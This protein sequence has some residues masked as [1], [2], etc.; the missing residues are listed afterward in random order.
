MHAHVK[1]LM[2]GLLLL[3]LWAFSSQLSTAFAQGTAF[4][5]QGQLTT[6]NGLAAGNYNFTFSLYTN[7]ASG[8]AVA[9]PVTNNAV[10]V[11]NGLF[12]TIVDFGPGVFNGTNYWL[13]LAVETN[14]AS[15]FANLSPRQLLTPAPYAIY[16]ESASNVLGPVLLSQ[17]PANV[18]TNNETNV[19]LGGTF[20]GNGT[21]L[22]IS[23]AQLP[24][25]VT[26]NESNVNLGGTF[27]GVFTGGGFNGMGVLTLDTVNNLGYQ[28]YYS[29]AGQLSGAANTFGNALFGNNGPVD[30]SAFG[31]SYAA[32]TF[33]CN[34]NAGGLYLIE[35][36]AE[37]ETAIAAGSMTIRAF[38]TVPPNPGA[39]IP[40][41]QVSLDSG[42]FAVGTYVTVSKS[43]LAVFAPGDMLNIQFAST[44]A[45]AVNLQ[46]PAGVIGANQPSISVTII[47]IQ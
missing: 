17:L 36:D 41:S 15:T 35:Y 38:H 42:A 23:V 7:S 37:V 3:A 45:G 44:V 43:F 5:Y 8:S 16:A 22:T 46:N 2:A 33:I 32:G 12:T 11:T 40:G 31:W 28:F 39:F 14:G 26:N 25:V 30:G 9:G 10:T 1:K 34:P 24:G 47:R 20:S 18:V 21:N 6:I 4:T 13:Q 19:T 29:L 27:N